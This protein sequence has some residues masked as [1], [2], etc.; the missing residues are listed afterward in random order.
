M[1]VRDGAL[2][3]LLGF[4]E[5]HLV[6]FLK[7]VHFVLELLL[8]HAFIHRLMRASVNWWATILGVV[9]ASKAGP[10][11]TFEDWLASESWCARRPQ[12]RPSLVILNWAQVLVIERFP[13]HSL[14]N[15]LMQVWVVHYV[16]HFTVL[17]SLAANCLHMLWLIQI[18]VSFDP[19]DLLGHLSV[20]LTDLSRYLD[21]VLGKAL[22][23]IKNLLLGRAILVD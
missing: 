22:Q 23:L 20:K 3:V 15:W 11:M 18:V 2:P 1:R 19:G 9:S 5:H 10:S 16:S 13:L 8:V 17:Q 14:L 7:N 12:V 21:S 6:G 4:I